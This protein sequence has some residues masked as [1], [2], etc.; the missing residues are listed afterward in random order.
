[1]FWFLYLVTLTL[2]SLSNQANFQ[3]ALVAAAIYLPVHLIYTY[4]IIYWLVPRFLIKEKYGRFFLLYCC[5]CVAGLLLNFLYRYY[6]ILPLREGRTGPPPNSDFRNVFAI[7]SFIVMN[8]VAMFGVFIKLFKYWHLEQK[9]KLHAEKEKV[10]AELQLLK[11]QLHPHFLFNTLNNL[12][13]LVYEKSD[14]APSMLLRLSGL[15]SYV[16][17]ECKAEEVR[18]EKEIQIIKDYVALEQERYG[19]RLEVSL[20][21]SGDIADRMIAPMLFQPFIENAFKHGTSE[22]L[23]NVWMN[24]ELSVK[25]NQLFFKIINS[26]DQNSRMEEKS[27]GIGIQNIRKRLELLYPSRFQLQYGPEGELYIV[28]LT[29]ELNPA[30]F[31]ND[32]SVNKPL[33]PKQFIHE[34][35]LL[36]SG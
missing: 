16:L 20:N 32:T 13:S 33:A 35:P 36:I 21:F 5:W 10:K 14:K 2:F 12:Y 4:T 8:T 30:G 11:S 9:Q 25:N 24:I 17:Y 1:M 34:D 28:T 29:I 6:I 23:G 3:E 18:L 31:N 7:F 22:Q 19:N 15:L 26:Y 27:G